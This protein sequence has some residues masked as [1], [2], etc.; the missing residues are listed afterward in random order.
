MRPSK[1][2]NFMRPDFR[3]RII[4]RDCAAQTRLRRVKPKPRILWRLRDFNR[5]PHKARK[6]KQTVRLSRIKAALCFAALQ[7]RL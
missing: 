2:L 1:F 5:L 6:T 7:R 3:L 4:Q